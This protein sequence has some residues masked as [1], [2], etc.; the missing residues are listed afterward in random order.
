MFATMS[1]KKAADFLNDR[2]SD[3]VAKGMAFAWTYK[4]PLITLAIFPWLIETAG[5]Y[6][7][8][9][10]PLEHKNQFLILVAAIAVNAWL[11]TAVV[12]FV[13]ETV[14]R[15]RAQV[16]GIMLD[17]LRFLPKIFLSYFALVSLYSSI[18]NAPQLL[19][20]MFPAIFLIWA[21]F[22]CAAEFYAP[23]SVDEDDS[24]DEEDSYSED[25]R[26]DLQAPRASRRRAKL[27]AGKYFWEIG[28]SRSLQFAGHRTALTLQTVLLFWF[29]N[30]VPS[31]L[32]DLFSA[33]H[34][35]FDMLFLKILL[36]SVTGI[37]VLAVA[38]V[39][40]LSSV[41][42]DAKD[43]LGL[44]KTASGRAEPAWT[45]AA[46]VAGEAIAASAPVPEA[47]A[48]PA[49]HPL[50]VATQMVRQNRWRKVFVAVLFIS[51]V[52]G[53]IATRQQSVRE[54][55]APAQLKIAAEKI[56]RL[57]TVFETRFTLTDPE[58]QFRWLELEGLRVAF[59]PAN[60]PLEVE[61][62]PPE[63]K[64]FPVGLEMLKPAAPG[65]DL[66]R[67]M[68][69]LIFDAQGNELN[70]ISFSPHYGP[71]TVVLYFGGTEGVADSGTLALYYALPGELG[72]EEL[73]RSAYS[74]QPVSPAEPPTA[75]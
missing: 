42:Q 48:G 75:K 9:S 31:S 44:P 63:P 73:F 71:V 53:S 68:R 16:H 41:P 10:R 66:S 55:S 38:V 26:Y 20:L 69:A 70:P 13:V 28:F 50:G 33:T 49:R 29:I 65:P 47:A 72:T 17:A 40:F 61:P 18:L 14:N 37:F 59:L 11:L 3:P 12:L 32:I 27:F 30:V 22:F 67:P 8:F 36:S 25:G 43:E 74:V 35:G 23:A 39:A 24:W 15:R 6:L 52:A 34:P 64:Q 56:E 46:A 4:R 45:P 5:A 19:P 51:S 2:I 1:S 62:R 57:G 54:R 21:P 7:Q 58:N 60:V